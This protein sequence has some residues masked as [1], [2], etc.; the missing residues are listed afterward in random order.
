MQKTN[1]TKRLEGTQPEGVKG[2]VSKHPCILAFFVTCIA[3][4]VY[5]F[6]TKTY[7]FGNDTLLIWDADRQYLPFYAHIKTAI[8][9]EGFWNY[10]WSKSLG[11]EVRS[12]FAYYCASPFYFVFLFV[13]KTA[14]PF[15]VILVIMLKYAVAAAAFAYCVDHLFE[16]KHMA[17]LLIA[18]LTYAFMGYNIA[19]NIAMSWIDGVMLLPL[20]VIGLER[21]ITQKKSLMYMVSL[22]LCVASNFYIGYMICIFSV[23][24]Y[25]VISAWRKCSLK[26]TILRFGLSSLLAGGM[27]CVVWLPIL[28]S[29]KNTRVGAT[30]QTLEF[31]ENFNFFDIFAKFYTGTVNAEEIK[32]DGLP[33]LYIGVI[34]LFLAV[35]Y[36]ANKDIALWKRM[37][38]FG[39][40]AF[41]AVSF[42]IAG[43]NVMWHGFSANACFNYRYSFLLTFI[44]IVLAYD[45][46]NRLDLMDP[47]TVCKVFLGFLAATI[48]IYKQGFTTLTFE[49]V[50]KDIAALAVFVVAGVAYIATKKGWIMNL[51]VCVQAGMLI[52]NAT[53][54]TDQ[55]RDNLQHNTQK[56]YADYIDEVQPAVDYVKNTDDSFCRMEKD[57][58]YNGCYENEPMLFD[59]RGIS[60]FS[61]TMDQDMRTFIKA[62][63]FHQTWMVQ[64]YGKGSTEGANDLMGVKYLLTKDTPHVQESYTWVK[65]VNDIHIYQDNDVLGVAALADAIYEPT[66]TENP[67]AFL[68]GYFQALDET[69]GE[70]YTPVEFGEASFVSVDNTWDDG[71]SQNKLEN[72][73]DSSRMEYTFFAEKNEP[74]YMQM[75]TNEY[76]DAWDVY[77][78]GNY[79]DGVHP[80]QAVM[81]LGTFAEGE[82]VTVSLKPPVGTDEVRYDDVRMYYENTDALNELTASVKAKSGELNLV[83]NTK[84]E[85]TIDVEENGKYLMFSIPYDKDWSITIDGEPAKVL[86]TAQALMAVQIPAGEHTYKLQYKASG[87]VVSLLITLA[88]I[89]IVVFFELRKKKKKEQTK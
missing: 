56:E 49:N 81:Y 13:P 44:L 36:F 82:Q 35:L 15:A 16:R 51:A 19:Y 86:K 38:C 80:N 30:S 42:Q 71:W 40:I 41:L 12:L 54:T 23:V 88:S 78:N 75:D 5:L 50:Y 73:S 46:L 83:K 87:S 64:L 85:G 31:R 62:M 6:F 26:G 2:A 32:N 66:D 45:A 37:T 24:L 7:P 84:L 27:S 57:F 25:F 1:R 60:H 28:R 63:G 48:L 17:F 67:F 68:N 61:S 9:D 18:S 43:L 65:D 77:V 10:S 34:M 21:L 69:V 47:G 20:V 55:I 70:I 72:I 14:V 79:L 58:S 4:W 29:L 3:F 89:A 39:L 22:A 11:G 74:L 53:L 33:Q 76:W 59:Y 8:L 52:F